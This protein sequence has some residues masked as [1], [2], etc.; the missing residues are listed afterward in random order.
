MS[1]PL[2]KAEVNVAQVY[3]Q[4]FRLHQQGRLQ[5]AESL[6][7]QVLAARPDHFD[8]LHMMGAI[9]HAKGQPVEALQFIAAAMRTHKPTSAI[10]YNQGLILK[11]LARPEDALVSFEQAIKQKSKFAEAHNDR[12]V[13]LAALGRHEEAIEAYKKAGALKVDFAEAHYNRGISL[14][15]LDRN[16]DALRANDR[17]LALN[18][19]HAKA[20][21]NRGIALQKLKRYEEALESYRRA[22]A[23]DPNF[24]KA[25]NNCGQTL[26]LMN[27]PTE[28]LALLDKALAIKS[29]DP[30]AYNN[31]GASLMALGRF[32]EALKSIERA[33]ALDPKLI[34]AHNDRGVLLNILSRHEEAL[35]SYDRALAIDPDFM[36]SYNNRNS[37]LYLLN[38]FDEAL[39]ASEK[40]IARWPDE[41]EAYYIRGR[42]LFE[43]NRNDEALADFE[44]TLA[45]KPSH[46][47][48][49]F[50]ACFTELPIVY[51]DVDEVDRRRAA[52]ERQLKALR[53]D[54]EAGKLEGVAKAITTKQP[55]YLAYQGRNDRDLQA[56]YGGMI[57]SIIGKQFPPAPLPPPPA[58]GEPVRVGI[59]SGF[60]MQHSNWKMPIKGWL[61]QLDRSRFKVYGYHLAATRDAITEYAA[62]LCERFVNLQM[63]AAGWR[64][65]I[66]AD[67]PHV[68]IYPGILMDGM[69]FQLAA[70]RLAPV[71]CNS[72]GHPETSGMPT[73][74]YFL[75]SDLMEPPEADALYTERLVR[76]P[77][78]SVYYEPVET[79]PVLMTRLGLG[80]RADAAVF[81]SG[82]SLFKY[83]PQFDD[84]FA[85]I[86]KLAPHS[87]FVFLRHKNAPQVTNVFQ[88]RL[89]YAFAAHGLSAR[90]YCVFLDQMGQSEFVAAMGQSDVFLDSIGW[91]GCNTSLESLPHNLP[92]VTAPGPLMRGRHSSAILRM[93]GVTDTIAA[94]L[95]DYVAIAA[96][97]A[98]DP[99]E[100]QALSRRMAKN[101]ERVYRD[102]ACIGGLEDFLD[103]AARNPAG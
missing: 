87:Q 86:A 68:L 39:A 74:D 84:V 32:E 50:G 67:A 45:L 18:P 99:S 40:S 41:A 54:V 17:T 35:A 69:S 93:I 70:Q 2:P 24:G 102:R 94:D 58:P 63:D 30:E 95:D 61:S 82:Q 79:T 22:L 29:D 6:Y 14:L 27:R 11:A 9:K 28:A 13:V 51:H 26:C 89:E 5:E 42:V 48:A 15:T 36:P 55:F 75:S 91:S 65:E 80:L 96:R 72:W 34:K 76:L 103:R 1:Q 81:W 59:V 8:A 57:S 90:D 78:L 52:Y 46:A 88:T 23:L 33:L 10:L 21:N 101:K 20:L 66:L 7:A 53:A 31:R 100:R 25:Y 44:H 4:A 71:Q 77:N 43:L 3:D 83:L 49:H 19:K 62:S 97:L 38:R 16:E 73:L 92:I 37:S 64:R 47:D 12:G 60:F 85:R 98:N 56:V